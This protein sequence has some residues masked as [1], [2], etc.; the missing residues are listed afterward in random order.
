MS[1]GQDLLGLA[2][3]HHFCYTSAAMGC[4]RNQVAAMLISDIYDFIGHKFADF[5]M[6][7]TRHAL[8]L[9]RRRLMSV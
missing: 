6:G 8:C 1:V 7:R 2:A 9:A 3:Q 4:N 5:V